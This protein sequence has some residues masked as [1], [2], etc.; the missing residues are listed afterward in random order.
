MQMS[1]LI[2]S[3][4]AVTTAPHSIPPPPTSTTTA[5]VEMDPKPVNLVDPVDSLIS[6]A[7]ASST[8]S[9]ALPVANVLTAAH[10]RPT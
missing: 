5:H 4:K 10:A 3:H 8:S 2:R 6:Q 7:S 9:V 1:H